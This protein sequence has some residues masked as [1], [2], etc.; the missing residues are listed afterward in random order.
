M[1]SIGP[2]CSNEMSSREE[3]DLWVERHF[4]LG[5]EV[6]IRDEPSSLVESFTTYETTER[7]RIITLHGLALQ[8]SVELN[9][10]TDLTVLSDRY[11]QS[12]ESDVFAGKYS[13]TRP[14]LFPTCDG[15]IGIAPTEV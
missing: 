2:G 12:T 14:Y 3:R 10:L 9:Q 13:Q 4:Q 5:A 7:G 11:E 8:G 1:A 15:D 6:N